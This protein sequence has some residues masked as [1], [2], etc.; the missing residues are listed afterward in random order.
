MS[1]GAENG[2]GTTRFSRAGSQTCT[3]CTTN[4]QVRHV[5]D[6]PASPLKR[7][8]LRS[9][10]YCYAAEFML[11]CINS[12]RRSN[13]VELINMLRCINSERRSNEVELRNM[14]WC[15]NSGRCSD[16]V[17]LINMLRCINSG[18]C[19]DDVELIN[20]LRCINPENAPT[21]WS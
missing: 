21:M 6:V 10:G 4:V 8:S 2:G 11:R 9:G 7:S 5:D 13:D 20:M 16:D 17:E 19:S 14:L 1:S 15:I 12:G 3:I 18:R